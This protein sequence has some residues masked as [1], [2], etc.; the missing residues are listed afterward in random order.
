MITSLSNNIKQYSISQWI[1]GLAIAFSFTLP[2]PFFNGK[3]G[4]FSVLLLVLW[5]AEGKFKEKVKIFRSI[6]FLTILSIAIGYMIVVL[7]LSDH[8]EKAYRS[9]IP[10]KYYPII[11]FII[12][13]SIPKEKLF[14]LIHAFVLGVVAFFLLQMASE[15]VNTLPYYSKLHPSRAVYSPFLAFAT[16]FYLNRLVNSTPENKKLYWFSLGLFAVLFSLLFFH[17]G[18]RAAKIGFVLG[19]LV[20]FAYN[21][22]SIARYIALVF[23]VMVTFISLSYNFSSEAKCAV[24]DLQCIAEE[25]KYEGSWGLRYGIWNASA[26]VIQDNMLFGVGLGDGP[27]ALQ[28]LIIR[29]EDQMFYSVMC[30]DGVHSLLV[31]IL[32]ELGL[33]GL[34]LYVLFLRFI[35]L[36]PIENIEIK[37]LST[38]FVVVFLFSSLADEIIFMKPYNNFFALMTAVFIAYAYK[39]FSEEAEKKSKAKKR[40]FLKLQNILN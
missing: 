17:A 38:T 18:G 23:L 40:N 16:L 2:M 20:I 5:I 12:L 14:S 21:R 13:T 8:L 7:A 3:V 6:K 31:Y 15:L 36:L 27:D 10:F 28:R 24:D 29:G 32:L 39:S 26:N 33:V 34:L 9:I 11:F 37:A 22:Q 1:Y 30:L 19:T 35:L 25:N 4:L